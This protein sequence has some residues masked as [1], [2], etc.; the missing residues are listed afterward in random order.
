MLKLKLGAGPRPKAEKS[1]HWF[2][3]AGA[4]CLWQF[5]GDLAP[6]LTSCQVGAPAFAGP[7]SQFAAVEANVPSSTVVDLVMVL[8]YR[9]QG[10]LLNIGSHAVSATEC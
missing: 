5:V 4:K 6:V 3:H 8:C 7:S 9:W 2:S 10:V 1:W